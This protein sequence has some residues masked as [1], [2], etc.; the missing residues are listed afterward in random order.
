MA[1]W[2]AKHSHRSRLKLDDPWSTYRLISPAYPLYG[3]AKGSHENVTTPLEGINHICLKR[4]AEDA[5]CF[6]EFKLQVKKQRGEGTAKAPWARGA[7]F[8]SSVVAT[9][10]FRAHGIQTKRKQISTQ[11]K[12]TAVAD[13]SSEEEK[14]AGTSNAS[15]PMDGLAVRVQSALD[16]RRGRQKLK[17]I[18]FYVYSKCYVSASTFNEPEFREMLQEG[19][20]PVLNLCSM[21]ACR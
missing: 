11:K 10:N 3:R 15:G 13:C 14:E 6:H 8:H 7:A 2:Y 16:K 20:S 12:A 18:L 19:A 5:L 4:D 1:G 21:L 9:H 17:Q